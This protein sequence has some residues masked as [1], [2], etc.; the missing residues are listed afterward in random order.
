VKRLIA[1]LVLLT[2]AGL[3]LALAVLGVPLYVCER[4]LNATVAGALLM[5]ILSIACPL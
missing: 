5:T 2:A 4:L 3:V 1:S